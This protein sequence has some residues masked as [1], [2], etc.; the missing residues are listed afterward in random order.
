[1]VRRW[2]PAVRGA[3]SESA[4]IRKRSSW[5]TSVPTMRAVAVIALALMLA[6]CGQRPA[7][8]AQ[9]ARDAARVFLVACAQDTPL[10]ATAQ[11]TAPATEAMPCAPTS[12]AR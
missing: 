12:L 9:Q 2:R 5:G 10:A 1:M 6:G 7:D 11:L 4:Q 8:T 3:R